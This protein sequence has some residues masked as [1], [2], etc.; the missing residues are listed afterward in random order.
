MAGTKK[1][2]NYS[3]IWYSYFNNE[4]SKCHDKAVVH[5]MM[6]V[7]S[8]EVTAEENGK[9]HSVKAGQCIFVK[10]DHKVKFTKNLF[11]DEPFKSVTLKFNR[12]FLRDYYRKHQTEIKQDTKPLKS[13]VFVI[14]KTPYIDSLFQ[15]MLPF[16]ESGHEPRAEF[17]EQKMQEGIQTLLNLNEGFYPSLFDFADPWKID[18]LDFLNQ[19]YMYDL[20]MEEI[21]SYTGRSLA[22]FKR[23]FRKISKL[24]PQKWLIQKRLR[25]AYELIKD[26][27]KKVTDVYIDVGF[28][29]RS[30]FSIAFKKMY[31]MA[32]NNVHS[33]M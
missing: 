5:F 16:F 2:M 25:K 18:I 12:S 1:S 24:T 9:V 19:N 17:I 15:S 6:Y 21:A 22:T 33:M 11:G 30:H 3:D 26:G 29:N 32:P 7:I 4:E 20:T 28:K 10:R 27:G 8:G 14:P 31:G 23:D 13:S